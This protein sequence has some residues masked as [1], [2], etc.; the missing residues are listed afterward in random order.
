MVNESAERRLKTMATI[1]AYTSPALGHLLPISALLSEL[2][3]RGHT[4]HLRT[5]SA[6][7]EIGQRLGFTTDAIDPR[8]EA[9]EHRRLEGNQ[10]SCRAEA[11]GRGVRPA[12]RARSHRSRRGGGACRPGRIA[13]RCELLGCSVGCRRRRH[14]VGVFF[15]IHAAAAISWGATVRAGPQTAARC[16]GPGARC[17]R[18]DHGD[19]A[20]REGN[21]AADQRDSR[22]RRS[23]AGRFDGRVSA[24]G[25]AD[26]AS[27][28]ASR[29][30][31]RKPIGAMRCR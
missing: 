30:S 2:S 4:I 20:C 31:T 3:H 26:A 24:P 6:G 17:R 8:I 28:A 29:S 22:G 7:V 1:L 21:A 18:A 25:A 12:R 15:A 9:I 19:R 16:V 13:C 11:V 23:T 10:S 27:R 14:P 5:L